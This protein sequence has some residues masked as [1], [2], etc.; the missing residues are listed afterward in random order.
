MP[1]AFN[2]TTHSQIAFGFF[3]IHSDMLLLQNLFFF[4]TDFCRWMEE[5]ALDESSKEIEA[6]WSMWVI[7]KAEDAGDLMG[8]IHGVRHVGFI[9]DTYLKYPFPKVEADFRQSPEGNSTQPEF[10]AMIEKYARL[11]AVHFTA[12]PQSAKVSIGEFGFEAAVF[13]E[14]IRYVWRGGYPR[15]R[16]E[17][18]PN[19]VLRMKE[20]LE[21]SSNWL[22][23]GI[24][25]RR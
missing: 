11:E 10:K 17:E 19:Y 22:V 12:E 16:N 18:R 9:G 7:D 3:N 6:S 8:A 15:W 14:L 21:K 13:R 25:W 2:S 4:A 20:L 23:T 5:L 1:L 24:D